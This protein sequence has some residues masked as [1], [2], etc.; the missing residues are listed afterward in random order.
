MKGF[1]GPRSE[2]RGREL[3]EASFEMQVESFALLRRHGSF[4]MICPRSPVSD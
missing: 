3:A 2:V 4:K 1:V